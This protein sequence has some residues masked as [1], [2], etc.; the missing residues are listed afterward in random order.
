MEKE[1]V[2]ALIS[3]LEIEEEEAKRILS[4]ALVLTG[5][6]VLD[7][8]GGTRRAHASSDKKTAYCEHPKEYPMVLIAAY[9][10][11][12][13]IEGTIRSFLD[14]GYPK[15]HVFVA[16]D[17]STDKTREL[18]VAILS[19]ENVISK[20]NRGKVSATHQ[21][22]LEIRKR[23]LKLSDYIILTDGDLVYKGGHIDLD[24]LRKEKITVGAFHV[25]PIINHEGSFAE[26]LISQL[27]HFEYLRSMN[28]GR[29]YDSRVGSVMCASG[30]GGIFEFNRLSK[31][32][33][34]HSGIFTGDDLER[35]LLDLL[36]KGKSIIIETERIFTFAPITLGGKEGL[37]QQR[38]RKWWPGMWRNIPLM[39]NI[40]GKRL[41]DENFQETRYKIPRKLSWEIFTTVLEPF[42]IAFIAG[43]TA[44]E[45]YHLLGALYLFYVALE[46]YYY[47]RVYKNDEDAP[48]ILITTLAPLY[49]LLQSLLKIA[50]LGEAINQKVFRKT[51]EQQKH[52]MLNQ[53]EFQKHLKKLKK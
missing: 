48:S 45:Q 33:S 20:K 15:S 46:S 10:E 50:A 12:D 4:T 52:H 21:A 24:Y 11:E 42:K 34:K 38:Y 28:V 1:V 29:K 6:S 16:D 32:M 22:I 35:T 3:I 53:E 14:A 44:K 43:V 8:I 31:L 51:W 13:G 25:T 30:A 27:Q 2:E 23:N 41:R 49:G 5:A 17:G 9:Q 18:S 7:G 37:L 26:R 36:Y 40:I 47:T 19:E 39:L